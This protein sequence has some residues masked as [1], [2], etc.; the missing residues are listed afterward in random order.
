[1]V[2][3]LALP[4]SVFAAKADGDSVPTLSAKNALNTPLG[5][6]SYGMGMAQTGN[7]NDLSAIYYNPAGL[8]QINYV[9]YGLSY[10][11]AANDVSGHS[12]LMSIPLPYGTLGLAGV[13][14]TVQDTEYTD[15]GSYSLPDRNKYSYTAALSYGMPIPRLERKLNFGTTVKWFG[16]NFQDSLPGATYP[17]QQKGLFID[18]GLLGTF[19]PAQYSDALRWLPRISAGFAA[20]N[21]HPLVAVDHEVQHPDNREEYNT[22]ISLHFP[23]KLMLNVDAVNSPK[24]TTRMRYGLEYWPAHFLALRGGLTKSTGDDL[25]TTIHWGIGF[26]ETVQNSKLSFEYSGA[27]EFP[28]GVGV[29]FERPS[30]TYH[31]FAFHHSFEV[32]GEERGRATPIRF[33][34][35]Y[36]HRY[37][38][39]RAL[40]PRE[41]IADTISSL[42]PQEASYDSAIQAADAS[43]VKPEIAPI[44]EQEEAP[45]TPG[46]PKPN[47][48]PSYTPISLG[49]YVVAVYPVDVEF[50]AGR[51]TS[52]PLKEKL[53]GNFLL[54]VS[55]ARVGRLI[56]AN[57]LT[58]APAQ[59]QGELESAY[60]KRLQQTLGADLIVFNKLYVD[61]N[62]G[63]LKL[64]TLY[65]K[66][67]DT[68]L[69][70]RTEVIGSD[71]EE[72]SFV[73]KATAQF[74]KSHKAL[75]EEL[76]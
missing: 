17:M 11:S 32:I 63:E 4:L 5:V 37:R 62:Y 50:V 45:V 6:R 20:R 40:S 19:D 43:D 48:K 16:A 41:I 10:Y 64:L 24:E 42:T 3:F 73:A 35:R 28:V 49:K 34:E 36:T 58:S 74:A 61:G 46:K 33:T 69:S 26:G 53:R 9:E 39:A 56:N 75:L 38:F 22:G 12:L 14:N 59:R 44:E 57:K 76:K 66:K 25:Y 52:F 72:T 51:A 55:R 65:Y 18:V 70:A 8:A 13:F 71:A 30:S 67:G 31:R 7:A 68:G 60:L 54:E 27:K 15:K 2:L 21:L 1:M 23:Y 29:N 47:Q